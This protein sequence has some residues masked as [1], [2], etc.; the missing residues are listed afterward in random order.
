M[1]EG[2]I[3]QD[4]WPVARTFRNVL[5]RRGPG[6][7]AL[8]VYH[9][10]EKVVDVWA[11]TRDEEGN[12]WNPD[13]LSV[14]YSTTKGVVSTVLHMLVDRGLLDY[15]DPVARH[16]PEFAEADKQDITVRQLMCH[17][18][19]LYDIHSM[20][21]HARRM[22][23]W[24]HMVGALAAARPCHPPGTAHGYHGFTYGWLIGEIIQRVTGKPLAR[25]LEEE[26]ANPL[27]LEGLFIGL[28]REA[29]SRRA[30]LI[31]SG[32]QT[33]RQGTER[34]RAQL[35]RAAIVLGGL[36]VPFDPTQVT[37]A[38]MP[39]GIEDLDFNSEEFQS[40][41]IP[42]ANGMFSARSLGRLYAALAAGGEIDGVRLLSR[43]T[44]ERATK[45]QN[46]GIGRVIPFPMHWRLGYHR[47][48]SLTGGIPSGFGH[49]GF[50]GSGAWAD[51]RRN[52]SVALVLNSGVGTPF[53]DTRIV[54]VS[55]TALRCAERRAPALPYG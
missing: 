31:M 13:T 50:G 53:G 15:D 10:G 34:F 5:P 49:F 22:L 55:T 38:L 20:I 18:A 42:A 8:V 17:E 11:G 3:H 30:Q 12:P 54:R 36:R 28:P 16:W 14:S 26:V 37:A 24:N 43:R 47:P 29:R 27:G 41:S 19:G 48:F 23:D 33:S 44:L 45:R 39:P 6:G 1:I 51:C 35:A 9:R 4:F 21:D 25:V 40:A 32:V 7:A 46:K 52:L 2:K